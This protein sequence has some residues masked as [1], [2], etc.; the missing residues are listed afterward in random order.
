M[1]QKYIDML[2]Y[3]TYLAEQV[4]HK[5]IYLWS[6]QGE[7][8]DTLPVGKIISMENSRANAARVLTHLAELAK[9]PDWFAK[10]A[11]AFDCSGLIVYWLL[12]IE[13]VYTWDHTANDIWKECVEIPE[14]N[15][16]PGD[17]VFSSF[18][19]AGRAGHIGAVVEDGTVTESRGRDYG[20]VN[21]KFSAGSWKKIG[22]PAFWA[23]KMNRVLKNGSRGNDVGQLQARLKHLGFDCGTVDNIFGSKTKSAL[24]NFQKKNYPSAPEFGVMDKNTAKKMGFV[25]AA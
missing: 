6:G 17:F 14:G 4:L 2:P 11:K 19:S 7:V 10:N 22:R 5:S 15:Q 3:L 16:Q 13:K 23:Y 8:V 21:R 20:V 12:N 18:S 1:A 24:T 25:F 9:D